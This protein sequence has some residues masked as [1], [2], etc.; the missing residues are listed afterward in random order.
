MRCPEPIPNHSSPVHIQPH[1]T[2]A[3][4]NS[5]Q[6]DILAVGEDFVGNEWDVHAAVALT[7]DPE[8]VG[9]ELWEADVELL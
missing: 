6:V 7:S 3:D 1:G 4:Q 5:L 9:F 8:S 2:V